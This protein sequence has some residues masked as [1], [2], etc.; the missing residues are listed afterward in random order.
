M[1]P[2]SLNPLLVGTDVPPI[3]AAQRWVDRYEGTYGEL[4]NLAQAVPGTAPPAEL[5][6][7]IS[8]SAGTP[9][10]ATYG[11]I[12]G[13]SV[14]RDALAGDVRAIYGA[15]ITTDDV[16]ITAGCNQGFFVA[17]MALAKAGDEIILPTPWYFNHKMTLDML[18]VVTR[19][20]P[21]L[22][23]HGFV[24]QAENARALLGP[25]TRAIVLVTPNNPTGAVYP[26]SVLAEFADLARDAGVAL[27]LDETYRDFLPAGQTSPHDLLATPGW[28]GRLLQL[29]SFS[30]SYAIPGHRLGAVIAAP[31][32]IGELAKVLDCLMICP[33]RA[34]QAAVAWAVAGTGD[35]RQAT[36]SR[37][38][39]RA[40]T[41]REIIACSP[42]WSI[43]AIGAYFAYV[44]H[45]FD[46][47]CDVVAEKL[48]SEVGVLTLPGSFFG[49]GQERHLRVAFAN[50]DDDRLAAVGARL[51]SL[52]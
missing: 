9:E 5:L 10:S 8:A 32:M 52:A 51:A 20:L 6:A 17:M 50:V 16:A 33:P 11:P 47:A 34:A 7:R 1:N 25:K 49:P 19:L 26:P 42:G 38:N 43:S 21:C 45:P 24:P 44:R 15:D 2:P 28:R 4:I 41:F 46:N 13:D 27:V 23:Q 12:L 37:I 35:W 3:P 22:E 30:K 29:Y 14:L 48:A 31:A 39:A 40:A 18:G 36:R